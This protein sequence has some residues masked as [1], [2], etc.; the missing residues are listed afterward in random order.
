MNKRNIHLRR[1]RAGIKIFNHLHRSLGIARQGQKVNFSAIDQTERNCR[2]PQTIQSTIHP[3]RPSLQICHFQ[4]P[5]RVQPTTSS[6][7]CEY[8]GLSRVALS[9]E[10]ENLKHHFLWIST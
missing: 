1:E 5:V 7:R 4:Y 10:Y 8:L 6:A 9:L 2:A 3:M